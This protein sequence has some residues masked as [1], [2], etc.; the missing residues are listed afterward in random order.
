MVRAMGGTDGLYCVAFTPTAH[1]ERTESPAGMAN[2]LTG[3][4]TCDQQL[5]YFK[6]DFA[7]ASGSY[8]VGEG[9]GYIYD[10]L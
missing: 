9:S 2:V 8:L 3:E 5:P 4:N 10:V 1:I 6:L 7:G